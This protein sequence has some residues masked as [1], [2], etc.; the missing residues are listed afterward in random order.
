M[1]LKPKI[2]AKGQSHVEYILIGALI[3][4]VTI[5]YL[6]LFKEGLKSSFNKT[7]SWR[8]SVPM[9]PGP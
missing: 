4:V 8:T 6:K 5:G 2:N 1:I 7:A 3:C 9:G